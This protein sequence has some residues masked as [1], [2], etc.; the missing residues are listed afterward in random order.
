MNYGDSAFNYVAAP[1]PRLSIKCT[2]IV[3][4]NFKQVVKDK[5]IRRIHPLV[6]Q[7]VDPAGEDEGA[8]GGGGGGEGREQGAGYVIGISRLM[9]I[10]QIDR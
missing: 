3:I 9:S 1:S 7:L 8:A 2:V 6:S 4:S 5:P 10:Q